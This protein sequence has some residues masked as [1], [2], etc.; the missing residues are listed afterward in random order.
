VGGRRL[1]L[2][3]PRLRRRPARGRRPPAAWH[4]A[5]ITE[6]AARFYLAH[7]LEQAGYDLLAQ[8]RQDYGAWGASAK[9]AQL[10]WAYP[11]LRRQSDGPVTTGTLDLLA[12][13]S[14]SQALSS[15]TSIEGLH[16][17]VVEV[18]GAMTGATGVQMLLWS[19]DR[20]DWL[21]PA[22]P[23]DVTRNER[24]APMSV[25][26]YAERAREALVVDDATRDDRFARDPYFADLESCSLLAVPV[27]SR[28]TLNAVL[29]LENR[30]MRGAFTTERL[31]AVK[32]I[33]GQLAVSLDNAQ[34]RAQ[35]VAS[36]ARIVA[37]A[38]DARRRV[39]RNLHDGAQQRVVNLGIKL[40]LLT[41]SD[42]ARACGIGSDLEELITDVDDALK[43]LRDLSHGLHPRLLSTGGLQ[44]ALTALAQRS[45]IPVALDLR[46]AGR[47]AEAVETATYYVVAEMLTNAAKHA[48]AS[49]VDVDVHVV[50]GALRVRVHDNGVG[51]ADPAGGSGL[52]GLRDRVEAL[53]GTISLDSPQSKGTTLIAELPLVDT[54]DSVQ[55][56]AGA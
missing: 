42:A 12:I 46:V 50:D 20:H 26:R 16:A 19:E 28:G 25:L 51:G 56:S 27:L 22:A 14:A 21:A 7:G 39:K 9:V 33:A 18:L 45:S 11:T 44:A 40:K 36:R 41:A 38:D 8:A 1:P 24:D 43:E 48:R 30:L 15:E 37:A 23:D 52:V 55:D 31:D 53:G 3:C 10:D 4:R 17:R 54:V 13:L 47:V 2:S 34:S 29:L 35:L 6:R 49:R 32:L 5:L